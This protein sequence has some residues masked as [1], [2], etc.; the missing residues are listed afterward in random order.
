MFD[1]E[2]ELLRPSEAGSGVYDHERDL[3]RAIQPSGYRISMSTPR[4]DD[5]DTPGHPLEAEKEGGCDHHWLDA[6]SVEGALAR[7]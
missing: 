3:T 4:E 1:C 2:A 5:T 6:I 7:A